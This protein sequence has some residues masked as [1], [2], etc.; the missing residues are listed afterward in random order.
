MKKKWIGFCVAMAIGTFLM[1][2]TSFAAGW[3]KEGEEWIYQKED[4]SKTV[5][6]LQDQGKWYYFQEDG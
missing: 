6:W 2:T 4:G 5:G 3:A 1:P